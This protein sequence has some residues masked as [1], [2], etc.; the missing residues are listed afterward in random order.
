[1]SECF[2]Q[3]CLLS[4]GRQLDNPTV[5]LF[6]AGLL[7]FVLMRMLYD[8]VFPEP[9]DYRGVPQSILSKIES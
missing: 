8:S 4:D 5:S 7:R 9:S 3:S 1:M 6:L 2:F